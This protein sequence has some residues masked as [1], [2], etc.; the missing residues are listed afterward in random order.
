VLDRKSLEVVESIK[1]QDMLGG[2]HQMATDS[3]W[4]HLHGSDHPRT[5]EVGV[6]ECRRPEPITL[7]LPILLRLERHDDS[8]AEPCG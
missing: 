1:G 8:N 5:P 4:Q 3:R 6:K 7:G 2:G